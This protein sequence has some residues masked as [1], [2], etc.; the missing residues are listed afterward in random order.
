MT[1][2]NAIDN[3]TGALSITGI[4]RIY[5]LAD[6]KKGVSKPDLPALV[7]VPDEGELERIHYGNVSTADTDT[8]FIIHRLL[9][10]PEETGQMGPAMA[11]VINLVDKY[12]ESVTTLTAVPAGACDVR[13]ARW[14]YGIVEWYGHSYYGCDFRLEFD[15]NE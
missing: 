4:D 7:I 10:R 6:I 14:K 8:H 13:V 5:D 1:L 3:F 9:E 2:Y 11:A 12:T 15:I